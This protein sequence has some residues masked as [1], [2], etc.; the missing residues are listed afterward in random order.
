MRA[1]VR[2]AWGAL[3]VAANAMIATALPACSSTRPPPFAA[4]RPAGSAEPALSQ[5]EGTAGTGPVLFS[6]EPMGG[7]DNAAPVSPDN[8]PRAIPFHKAPPP[9]ELPR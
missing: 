4:T 2:F 7:P 6:Q 3:L 5:A 8:T 9:R 1:T